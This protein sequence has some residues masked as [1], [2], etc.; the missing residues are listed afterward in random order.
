M[1]IEDEKRIFSISFRARSTSQA[2]DSRLE[3]STASATPVFS[4]GSAVEEG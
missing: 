4:P 3:K 2:L 1:N